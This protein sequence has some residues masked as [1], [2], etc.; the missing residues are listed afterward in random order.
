M[1]NQVRRVKENLRAFL[2]SRVG[3]D[4]IVVQRDFTLDVRPGITAA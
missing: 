2:D 3:A 4:G 1:L